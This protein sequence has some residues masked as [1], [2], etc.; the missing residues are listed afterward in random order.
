MEKHTNPQGNNVLKVF[1]KRSQKEE[2]EKLSKSLGLGGKCRR[3]RRELVGNAYHF[4]QS[5]L[6][7]N[8]AIQR[9]VSDSQPTHPG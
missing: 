3:C 5:N 7:T 9:R 1:F 8:G 2:N 4:V 6:D